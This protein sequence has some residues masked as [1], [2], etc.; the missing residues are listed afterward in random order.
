VSEENVAV[1]LKLLDAFDRRDAET[2][3]SLIHPEVVWDAEAVRDYVPDLAGTYHGHAGVRQYWGEWLPAWR[4]IAFEVQ[5]IHHRGDDVV[6]LIEQRQTGHASGIEVEMPPYAILFRIEGGLLSLW[7]IYGDR[8]A[9]LA[10][11]GLPPTASGT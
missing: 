2:A 3:Y 1:V 11:I 6:V 9:A 5:G 7:R 8:D 10:A 4:E